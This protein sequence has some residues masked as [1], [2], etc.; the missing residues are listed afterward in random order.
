MG[1]VSKKL[2]YSTD[3]IAKK[4]KDISS[5]ILAGFENDL[6]NVVFLGIQQKGVPLAKRIASEIKRRKGVIPPVGTLDIS[7]YRDDLGM[8]RKLPFIHE[9][10]I[11]YN[12]EDKNI[13]LVDDVLHKG[14]TIRAALDAITDYGRP[15][16]IKLAV[17]IDRGG[18]EFPIQPDY[19]GYKISAPDSE[20]ISLS[21]SEINGRDAVHVWKVG[22]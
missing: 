18:R 7:M 13:I 9:T 16:L 1:S 20:R 3:E 22:K 19:A 5:A 4:I 10:E 2:L 14:R 6:E 17:L 21:W 8:R 12:L 11:P 15:R